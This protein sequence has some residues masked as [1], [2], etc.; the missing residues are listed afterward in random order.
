MRILLLDDQDAVR[1]A[2]RRVLTHGGHQVSA[3]ASAADAIEAFRKAPSA[4]DAA[5]LDVNIGDEDGV[6]LAI[7][8]RALSPALPIAFVTG[9]EISAER[10]RVH[11][12]VL[13]KPCAPKDLLAL[14]DGLKSQ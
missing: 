2:T 4:F 11:G 8:L 1:D 6:A 13:A 14:V 10:A 3:F 5:L 7:A 9:S 12:A